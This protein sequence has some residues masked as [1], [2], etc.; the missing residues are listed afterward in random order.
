MSFPKPT[1][2][3]TATQKDYVRIFRRRRQAAVSRHP[4]SD[5]FD[6][7]HRMVD[8]LIVDRERYACSTFRKYKS[9]FL[10]CLMYLAERQSDTSSRDEVLDLR[11]TLARES[12]AG[13][14]KRSI[15][16]SAQ[17]M[18]SVSGDVVSRIR[19]H[20]LENPTKSSLAHPTASAVTILDLSGI[21]PCELDDMVM[22]TIGSDGIDLDV[23]TAKRTN[24]RGLAERRI[25]SLRGLTEL[26]FRLVMAWP[27]HLATLTSDCS[28]DEAIKKLAAYFKDVGRRVLGAKVRTPCFYTFRHQVSAD[29]KSVGF[30]PSE[31]GSILGH[32]SDRT[33][34]IHYARK[35]SGRGKVKV[36]PDAKLVAKVRRQAKTFSDRSHPK[37]GNT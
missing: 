37:P 6:L 28:A 22:I 1:S 24:G 25:I 18:R 30:V 10:W 13:T 9:A 16:T 8:D 19:N 4:D 34:Q 3:V 14:L 23:R 36:V 32:A 31:T 35:V 27:S 5:V 20:L 17:K 12:V 2:T 7:L 29:M 33:N 26:E 11:A 21:R 15:R